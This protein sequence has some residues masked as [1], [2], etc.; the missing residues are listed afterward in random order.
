MS[1]QRS[2]W[3]KCILACKTSLYDSFKNFFSRVIIMGRKKQESAQFTYCIF[4]VI[5]AIKLLFYFTNLNTTPFHLFFILTCNPGVY[6]HKCKKK[7]KVFFGLSQ[8][9]GMD[10]FCLST[11]TVYWHSPSPVGHTNS[12]WLLLEP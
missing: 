8:R 11:E 3:L 4:Q 10:K 7:L 9:V 1:E 2:A 6:Y 12:V 5:L